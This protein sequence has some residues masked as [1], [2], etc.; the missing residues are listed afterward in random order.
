MGKIL[1]RPPNGNGF[2]MSLWPLV[3]VCVSEVEV[4]Y[5]SV[6]PSSARDVEHVFLGAPSLLLICG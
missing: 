3:C 2:D 6:G 1:G 5:E 4:M